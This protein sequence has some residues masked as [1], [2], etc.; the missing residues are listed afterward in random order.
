[1]ALEVKGTVVARPQT[2]SGT[3][4]RG[5]WRKAF[6]VIRYEEGQYPKEAL[7]YNMRDAEK[8]DKL[9]IGVR[10]TF[11]FDA[12]SRQASNGRWYCELECWHWTV[13]QPGVYQ[14]GPI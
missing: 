5:P 6:A 10:G 3:S 13:D 1:M 12:K 8:F 4:S 14:Q 9:T 7:L 11:Q 2:E